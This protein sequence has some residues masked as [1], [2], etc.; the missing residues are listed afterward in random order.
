VIISDLA[1][2][3]NVRYVVQDVETGETLRQGETHNLVTNA[4]LDLIR[5]FLD[6]QAPDGLTHFAVGTDGTAVAAGDTTLGGEVFR[7]VFTQTTPTAQT[8]AISYF[9]GSG[10]ANSNSLAEAGLFN[11]AS[12][13]TMFARVVLSP[14]IAKTSSI[15]VTFTWTINLGAS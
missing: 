12:A 4:G 14:A 6:S 3:V 13:G 1:A 7:D 10:D 9:L 2:R 15:A 5:D 11:D 8:L